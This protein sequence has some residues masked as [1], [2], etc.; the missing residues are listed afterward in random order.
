MPQGSQVVL[1]NFR[2]LIKDAS[3]FVRNFGMAMAKSAPHVYLSTLPFAPTCSHVAMQYSSMFPQ[4]VHVKH[5]KLS[6]WPSSEMVISAGAQV[7]SIALSP[8]G[9][10]IVSG[11]KNQTI[12]VWHATTGERVA[13]P[14]HGH[15]DEV[16]SVAFSPNGQHIVSGSYDKT[17]CVWDAITGQTV[18]GPLKRHLDAVVSVAISS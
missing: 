11:S 10:H 8:D 14:F 15:S 4:L 17:I 1:E 7:N 12:C 6:H 13:G 16:T 2:A 3:A 9:Q 18:I 5:G